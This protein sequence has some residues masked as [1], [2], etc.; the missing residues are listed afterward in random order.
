M[1]NKENSYI[2]INDNTILNK[3]CIRWVKKMNEC[4][5][6]CSLSTGCYNDN[7]MKVCKKDNLKDYNELNRHFQEYQE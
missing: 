7:T 6:I 2:K 4:L 3:N 1:D 5:E